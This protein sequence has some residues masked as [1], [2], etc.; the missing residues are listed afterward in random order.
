MRTLLAAGPAG[1]AGLGNPPVLFVVLVY[2]V[3]TTLPQDLIDLNLFADL[4]N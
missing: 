4:Q 2:Q 1:P 3:Y